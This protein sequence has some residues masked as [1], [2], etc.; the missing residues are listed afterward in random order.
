MT[1]NELVEH[2]KRRLIATTGNPMWAKLEMEIAA[3][4]P[5]ALHLLADRIMRD[6][7][8]RVHLQQDYTLALSA[9]GRGL[10]SAATASIPG[11]ILPEGIYAGRVVDTNGE[12]L[13]P[14]KTYQSFLSNQP[15]FRAYY[16]LF[17]GSV[18]TR[19]S[20]VQV[21]GAQD[22]QPASG[23]LTITAS[24]TPTNVS[25]VPGPITDDLVNAVV[26]VAMKGREAPPTP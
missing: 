5:V 8:K 25:D 6:D 22:V 1:K 4:I 3:S 26:E 13:W 14:L 15:T 17:N 9:Q 7:M 16:G 10:L 18:Y 11:D 20:G 12:I 2:A 23:P 24:F 19:A 21:N